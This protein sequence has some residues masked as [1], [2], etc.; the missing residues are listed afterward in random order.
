MPV[1]ECEYLWKR[2]D[3][4][5]L[6]EHNHKRCL[7]ADRATF[8]IFKRCG[9]FTTVLVRDFLEAINHTFAWR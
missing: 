3:T 4:K 5:D 7:V 1:Y 2:Q 9:Y 6:L 8:K